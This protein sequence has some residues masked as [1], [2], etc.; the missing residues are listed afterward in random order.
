LR[1]LV[2]GGGSIRFNTKEVGQP[3][4]KDYLILSGHVRPEDR[5]S[6]RYLGASKETRIGYGDTDNYK[7]PL[8]RII[9]NTAPGHPTEEAS[10]HHSYRRGDIYGSHLV[11]KQVE[12]AERPKK[13]RYGRAEAI[14]IALAQ[15][16]ANRST[17]A[18][19]LPS[20]EYEQLI[21]DAFTI[22]DRL[23]LRLPRESNHSD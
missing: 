7:V 19:D 16:E 10:D 11:R 1:L 18:F 6:S 3:K 22:L 12:N 13:F 2:L 5:A 4:Q 17:L 21:A 8:L 23:P 14:G 15:Y 9:A 20:S